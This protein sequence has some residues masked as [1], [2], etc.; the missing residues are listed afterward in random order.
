MDDAED[1]EV[2]RDDN[3][4][5]DGIGDGGEWWDIGDDSDRGVR[6]SVVDSNDGGNDGN[7]GD[8]WYQWWWRW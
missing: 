2:D 4:V 1:V 6:D 7:H 5:D 8:N 3:N